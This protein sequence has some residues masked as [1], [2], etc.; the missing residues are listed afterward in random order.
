[1]IKII[2]LIFIFFFFQG[3][4]RCEPQVLRS[5]EFTN[6]RPLVKG[7]NVPSFP[8]DNRLEWFCY[9]V[10]SEE[11]L[12][13]LLGGYLEAVL[14]FNRIDRM[15]ALQGAMLKI[16]LNLEKL[17]NFSPLSNELERAKNFSRYVFIDISEQFLGAYEFGK[18]KFSMPITSGRGSSTPRGLFKVLG[19]DRWHRSHRY[20][21]TGTNIPYPMYWGIKFHSVAGK[22][23]W[24]H[25]RDLPGYP[26]SHGCIGLYDE[27]MQKKFYGYPKEPLL[28]DSKKFYLWIFPDGGEKPFYYPEGLPDILIEIK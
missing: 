18:L 16:P 20:T 25:S 4:S 15:H 27:E 7:C 2:F 11:A 6:Q 13:K 22:N 19:R 14:R 10:R 8:S 28:M 5:I 17:S 3:I 12:N 26:A 24:I 21:I 1:V 9:K 23:F